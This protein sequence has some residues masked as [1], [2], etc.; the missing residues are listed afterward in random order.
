MA[1]IKSAY[2][3][4]GYHGRATKVDELQGSLDYING[5]LA[6]DS[7]HIQELYNL[8]SKLA[9]ELDSLTKGTTNGK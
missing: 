9:N 3:W 1:D 6:R 8:I 4:A 2:Y 7:E 5:R